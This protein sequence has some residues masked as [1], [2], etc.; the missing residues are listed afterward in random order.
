MLCHGCRVPWNWS[1][2]IDSRELHVGAHS[3]H[4]LN[5]GPLEEPALPLS[6]WLFLI[7]CMICPRHLGGV[8]SHLAPCG[9]WESN[10]CYQAW[11]QAP[12]RTE[13]SHWPIAGLL[14]LFSALTGLGFRKTLRPLLLN[15]GITGLCHAVLT[16]FCFLRHYVDQA[17]FEVTAICLPPL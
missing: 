13:P 14:L 3:V 15:T 12:L 4:E 2:S 16:Y 5:P 7:F 11:Q 6:C 10:S 9:F 8:I 17:D 1:Y